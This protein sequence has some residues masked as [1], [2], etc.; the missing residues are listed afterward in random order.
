VRDDELLEPSV[1]EREL[2]GERIHEVLRFFTFLEDENPE[3]LP[4]CVREVVEKP[5]LSFIFSREGREKR[6]YNEKEICYKKGI[7][8][9]DRVVW[10]GE[11]IYVVDYKTGSISDEDRKTLSLYGA[12]LSS[13]FPDMK[14][15]LYF[16]H[17]PSGE[18]EELSKEEE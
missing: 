16:L 2:E 18:L 13:L 15:S 14:V 9:P 5:E 1:V 3:E 11:R 10:D 4:S 17:L 12:A 8:R 7:L 6:V